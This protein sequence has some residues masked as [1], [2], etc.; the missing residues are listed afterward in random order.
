MIWVQL[1]SLLAVLQ[2]FAFGFLVGRA[3]SKYKLAAPAMF[4]HPVVERYIRAHYNTLEI[5]VVFL[6]CLWIAAQ[7]WSGAL[8]AGLGVI[9]LVG[10]LVFFLGYV[11]SP[12]KRHRGFLLSVIPIFALFLLALAGVVRAGM[13]N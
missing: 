5:I 9:Y 7:Y 4:G 11:E 1:V 3:R 6:A 13:A 10:R 8:V 2:L 12:D